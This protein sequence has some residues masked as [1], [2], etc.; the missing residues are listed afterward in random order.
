MNPFNRRDFLQRSAILSAA[1]AAGTPLTAADP[2][3]KAEKTGSANE[4]LK[5]AVIGVR[6]RGMSH[7]GGFLSK[8]ANCE[9]TTVCDCDEAVIGPA[10]KKITDTQGAAPKYVKDIRKVMEDKSIDIISVATPNHWHALA[11]VWA[12]RAGKDVY[13]EKP[14]THN[15]HEGRL[16]TQ[17]ARKYNRICQVGTQSRSTAGMREAIKYIHD[18]NIGKVS[19]A[20]GTCYKPRNSIGKVSGDQEPPKTMD[21]DLWCGPAHV[22]APHRKTGNGTVHYDWHWTWEYGNGD[23]GNQGVHEADKAR[24]GLN[25]PGLPTSVVSVGGRFGY[26]DDGETPNTQLNLYEYP[27]AH[28]IFEVRGLG[29][30][31]YMGAKVGNIWFGEKGYVVCPSYSSG[32]AFTPDGQKVKEFKGGGDQ[33]HFDNFVKAVRSRKHTDLNCDVEQGHLSAALCHLGNISYRLGKSCTIADDIRSFDGVVAANEGFERMKHHL[34]D[35]KVDTATAKGLVGVKLTIDP[36]TEKFSGGENLAKANEMLFREYR[37]GFDIT[38][39]V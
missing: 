8:N 16:M 12:M 37:K 39:A 22:L 1:V 30:K 33:S 9:I 15:V 7:V 2:E 14:A 17:A 19:L 38:E 34:V 21:Y 6:G 28:I 35:N 13:C 3:T 27:G 11:A 24:W 4:R 31:D 18:G 10:M 23:F 25:L 32:T 29:T 36:K 20:Y 5:V 26:V